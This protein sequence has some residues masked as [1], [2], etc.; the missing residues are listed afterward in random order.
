[1]T[2]DVVGNILGV[3]LD[4]VREG[5]ELHCASVVSFDDATRGED[6]YHVQEGLVV[7]RHDGDGGSGWLGGRGVVCIDPGTRDA[8]LAK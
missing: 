5:R 7:R 8:R 3:L 2:V 6:S 1:V 4:V